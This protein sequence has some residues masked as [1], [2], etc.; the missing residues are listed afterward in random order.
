MSNTPQWHKPGSRVEPAKPKPP[1]DYIGPAISAL[2]APGIGK[3]P[4]DDSDR[5]SILAAIIIA[6]ALDR[7][8]EKLIDAA[9]VSQYKRGE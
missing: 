4:V 5:A 1:R 9:A 3:L 8:G 6:Q 2:I 7:F